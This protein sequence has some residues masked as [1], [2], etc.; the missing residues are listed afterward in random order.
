MRAAEVVTGCTSLLQWTATGA[1]LE[2]CA[3][4]VLGAACGVAWGL[5]HGDVVAGLRVFVHLTMC[6]AAAGAIVGAFAQLSDGCNPLAAS[7]TDR[8]G[9][10]LRGD[11][12]AAL[13]DRLRGNWAPGPGAEQG[14]FDPTWN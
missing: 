1:A 2:A 12:P 14:P 11:L 4:A 3:G 13:R 5:L 7:N 6:A 9:Q 10:P 8:H